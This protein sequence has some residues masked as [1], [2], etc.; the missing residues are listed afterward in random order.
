MACSARCELS[1]HVPTFAS[2]VV[3]VSSFCD[4]LLRSGPVRS[5]SLGK[6]V[7]QVGAVGARGGRVGAG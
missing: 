6:S 1:P 5:L 3:S 4:S 2:E 7:A